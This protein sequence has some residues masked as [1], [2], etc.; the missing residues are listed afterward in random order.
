MA[1]VNVTCPYCK[2]EHVIKKG[3]TPKG[4]QRYFCKDRK[5]GCTFI[6]EY[7]NNGCKPGIN[8]QVIDM[9]MN[10][11]GVRDTA[12][13]LGISI[14]TARS[15][16]RGIFKKVGVKSQSGLVKEF[17]KALKIDESIQ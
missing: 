7:S 3:F 5:C 4:V 15:Q 14:N 11:S 12:R 9:G 2:G 8:D 10:G 13:V 16:L 1:T 17:A 6:L